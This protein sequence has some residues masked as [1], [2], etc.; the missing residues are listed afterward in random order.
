MVSIIIL[1]YNK[2]GL[3]LN[4]LE[5]IKKNTKIDYEIIVVDN[6]DKD[7]PV[8]EFIGTLQQQDGFQVILNDENVGFARGVNQGIK[9]AKGEH[10]CF[11]N[12]DTE[13]SEEWL[14]KMLKHFDKKDRK[15]KNRKIGAVAPMSDVVMGWQKRSAYKDFDDEHEVPYL[16]GLCLLI[17]RKVLDKVGLLDE[18]FFFGYEDIDWSIRAT[19]KGYTLIIAQDV[20]VRHFGGVSVNKEAYEKFEP[21]GKKVMIEKWGIERVSQTLRYRPLVSIAL[22]YQQ[23][24]YIRFEHNLRGLKRPFSH[25]FIETYRTP[26]AVARNLLASVS[27]RM[28]TKYHFFVDTDMELPPDALVRLMSHKKDICSGFAYKRQTPYTPTT[29]KWNKKKLIFEW[30]D[31]ANKG[32]RR[33]DGIGMF[34]CLIRTKVF[35]QFGEKEVPFDSRHKRQEDLDFCLKVT[36][37]GFSIWCDTDFEIIHLGN[38][39]RVGRKYFLMYQQFEKEIREKQSGIKIPKGKIILPNDKDF[40]IK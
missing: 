13:V 36:N 12:D 10:I 5:K 28:G 37:K 19:D 31:W 18:K 8:R 17:P 20:F 4:T 25:E 34:C 3:F 26:T 23:I 16:I 32:L 35:E 22:P 14:T 15:G 29:M 21:I 7:N 30:R 24:S 2:Y 27:I 33:I 6:S 38:Q 40:R 39:E 1:T 11:L 9:I